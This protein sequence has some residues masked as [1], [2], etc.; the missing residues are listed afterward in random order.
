MLGHRFRAL[1]LKE[2]RQ[3]LRDRRIAF[4]AIAA[5]FL[6]LVIFGFV[7][8]ATVTN[9]PLGVV[10]QSRTP[11]SRELVSALTESESFRLAGYYSSS[12][13]L[14][15]ALSV[16][17][18]DAGVVIPYDYARD[19]YERRTATVQFLLNATN[20]NIAAIGQGYA[21]GVIQ[22]YNARMMGNR[23]GA[24][25]V[26]VAPVFLNNPGLAGSWFMVTGV[27]GLLLI[28]NGSMLSSTMMIKE[29]SAGTLEQL[30][31]SPATT[32][33]IIIAKITPLFALLGTMGLVSLAAIRFVFGVPFHGS[34][35]V[36]LAG[37]ALCML[38]GIALGMFVATIAKTALQA[39]LAVFFLNPPFA[40]L[41][42]AFT[43]IE[44]MPKWLQPLTV[45]NPIAHF[46]IITRG[47]LIKG[48][49]F[50]AL[51]PN[52]LALLLFTLVLFTFSVIRYRKQLA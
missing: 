52:F 34:I 38:S 31:M 44:A 43:P 6:Q 23:G 29:R 36:V 14:G 45:L 50:G 16:G 42:G 24:L 9:L 40:S 49:G 12:N 25:P 17:T 46:G 28:L 30:L 19:L 5:P 39:Q 26:A 2:F 35:I 48:S 7:L 13:R 4:V 1:L 11:E 51:W 27:L 3:M 32:S 18:L 37:G 22:A 20:S 21:A 47:A 41:S 15:Q 8:S 10:D 33:E